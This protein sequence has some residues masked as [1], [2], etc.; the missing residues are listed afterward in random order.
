M[1]SVG[2]FVQTSNNGLY[3]IANDLGGAQKKSTKFKIEDTQRISNKCKV[4]CEGHFAKPK[5]GC[6][7]KLY[8]ISEVTN[9]NSKLDL[10]K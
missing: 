8:I 9:Q 7:F 6:N 2:P 10:E 4:L 5:K 1:W 3:A